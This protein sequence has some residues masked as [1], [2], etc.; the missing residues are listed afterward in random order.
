MTAEQPTFQPRFATRES[1]FRPSP[2]RAVFELAMDPAYVSLAGG[3]PD[4]RLLPHAEIAE[5]SARLIAERGPEILQYGSGAGITNIVPTIATLMEPLGATVDKQHLL[6]TTGSQMGI[7]LASKLFCNPGDVILTEGP[8]YVGALGTFGA[9]EIEV[10]HAATDDHGL[11]PEAVD[12]ALTELAAAGTPAR[13]LYCIPNHQNPTGVSLSIERRQALVDICDRHQVLIVEDDPYAYVGFTDDP[14]PASLYALNPNG[15]IYL[16]S[17]SKLFSPGLR[18]GWMAAPPAVRARLQIAGESVSIHPTVL[19]QEIAAAWV[20]SPQWAE[21]LSQI[22]RRYAERAGWLM[23]ALAT[24]LPSN[25]T[26]TRPQGGFFSWLTLPDVDPGIDLL[27]E[28][29]KHKLV[30][31]PG[32]ASFATPPATSHVRLAYSNATQESLDEGVRRLAET[33]ASLN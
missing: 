3:N 23:E 17:F 27:Q 10:R 14:P 31:V 2:V 4:T 13:F 30:L 33:L 16:G 7:D 28:A 19:A 1:F 6:I 29:I 5:L 26:W 21:N 25:T 11:I 9:Y 32:A 12:T 20:A 24:Y 15:V 18:V 22:R 8:T